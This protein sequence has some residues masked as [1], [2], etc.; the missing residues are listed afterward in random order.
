MVSLEE[1]QATR[2]VAITSAQNLESAKERVLSLETHAPTKLQA[3][4]EYDLV[5]Y[6][7]PLIRKA[8][9]RGERQVR[10]YSF[11]RRSP[12][13]MEYRMSLQDSLGRIFKV[14]YRENIFMGYTEVSW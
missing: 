14:K 1:G 4:V 3:L 12:C 13:E 2:Y 5:V 7:L 11:L 6:W 8:M 9:E 10:N